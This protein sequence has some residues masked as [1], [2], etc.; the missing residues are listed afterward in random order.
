MLNRILNTVLTVILGTKQ[1]KYYFRFMKMTDIDLFY[2]KKTLKS[3][4]KTWVFI[5]FTETL[6][7]LTKW[8]YGYS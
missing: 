8:S 2:I 1:L 4:I 6:G 7:T 5:L 3:Y